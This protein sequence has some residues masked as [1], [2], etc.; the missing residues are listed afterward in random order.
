MDRDKIEEK[1]LDMARD[2]LEDMGSRTDEE[3]DA[4][5]QVSIS[6]TA[7][8][9]LLSLESIENISEILQKDDIGAEIMGRIERSN[10]R[11]CLYDAL[12]EISSDERKVIKMYYYENKSQVEISGALNMSKSK[13]SRLHMKILERLKHKL[14]SKMNKEWTI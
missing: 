11:I 5:L 4:A 10:E 3:R 6:N 2:T 7:V 13:V 8:V 14:H 1:M 9:Y 12:S